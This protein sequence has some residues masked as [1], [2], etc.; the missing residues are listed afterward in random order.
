[1][2]SLL[3]IGKSDVPTQNICVVATPAAVVTVIVGLP[4]GAEPETL[5]VAVSDVLPLGVTLLKVS[6]G[7]AVDRTGS[8]RLTP[9]IVTV[10]M[11]PGKPLEGVTF[12]IKG[13]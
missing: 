12:V 10:T 6:P 8:T 2:Y 11:V 1:M 4:G 13:K 3:S 5:K 9:A 7:Q